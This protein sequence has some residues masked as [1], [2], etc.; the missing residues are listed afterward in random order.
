MTLVVA[1]A[2]AD[3]IYIE[4]D[5]KITDER[6]VRSDPLCGVLKTIIYHPFLCISFS[7]N[8]ALAEIAIKRLVN[9]K[10]NELD[11]ILNTLLRAN[12]DSKNTT[13]FIVASIIRKIPRLFR[14]SNGTIERDLKSV[15][16]GD[17][18]GFELYQANYHELNETLPTK[19]RML[20]AFKRVIDDSSIP[21]IGDFHVSTSVDHEINPGHPVFRYR[22]KTE[23]IVTEPQTISI[24]ENGTWVNIPLGTTEGGSH[25]LSYLTTVSPL[26]HGI[27]IHFTHGNFGALFC[28]QLNFNGIL[29]K[30][31]SGQEFADQIKNDYCI[32]LHGFIIDAN[33][34]FK[35]ID[36]RD[37]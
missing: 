19:D 10:L 22:L 15:W 8:V 16:I 31:V 12:I 20:Q 26:Y 14:V 13:D 3:N 29:I 25:G 9:Q 2:T 6:L 21:T 27:A 1:R 17:H 24:P 37:L 35:L 36:T 18:D 33:D 4:S 30:N 23:V 7:G 32:P 5:S 28:P 11:Q 34:S